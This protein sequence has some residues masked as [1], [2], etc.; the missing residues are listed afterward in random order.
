MRILKDSR[1]KRTWTLTLALP[2]WFVLLAKFAVSG[3]S[4]GG[5]TTA[6]MSALE[7]ATAFGVIMS[8]WL[9]REY[10]EKKFNGGGLNGTTDKPV[11]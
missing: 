8:T 9:V 1:G 4:Y 5:W 7:F 2:A 3:L 6:S 10:E 11:V